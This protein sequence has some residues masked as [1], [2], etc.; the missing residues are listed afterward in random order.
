MARPPKPEN[1]RNPLRQ[2]RAL[3]SEKGEIAP[4][5]Q[6]RL[7]EICDIPTS[8]IR[9]I[10]AGYRT[11]SLPAARKIVEATTAKWNSKRG[12]W[13][14]YDSDKPL[15]FSWYLLHRHFM[16]QRPTN[17]QSRIHFIH[18]KIDGLFDQIPNHSWNLLSFRINDFLEECRRDFKLK[19]LDGIF[20]K[21]AERLEDFLAFIRKENV[22]PMYSPAALS[23]LDTVSPGARKRAKRKPIRPSVT[24]G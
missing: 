14:V 6:N 1:A 9:S 16:K 23:A 7:S 13:T 5:T 20:Y 11:L 12:Q 10:E 4:I 18:A 2:L 15:T 17:Y 22:K 8:T 19:N 24:S 3:L 21:A